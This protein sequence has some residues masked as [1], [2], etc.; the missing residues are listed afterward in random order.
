MHFCIWVFSELMDLRCSTAV[1]FNISI[2]MAQLKKQK[3]CTLPRMDER[4]LTLTPDSHR[5]LLATSIT[6]QQNRW[7]VHEIIFSKPPLAKYSHNRSACKSYTWMIKL[8]NLILFMFTHHV[9]VEHFIQWD[10]STHTKNRKY[11]IHARQNM[12][13]EDPIFKCARMKQC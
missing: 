10:N 2:Q 11:R 7:W 4:T 5:S 12:Q 3:L 8:T 6:C 1:L 13:L 9:N